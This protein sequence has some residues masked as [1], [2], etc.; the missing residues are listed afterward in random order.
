MLH[1]IF[2]FVP[3]RRTAANSVCSRLRPRFRESV[4]LRTPAVPHLATV[5]RTGLELWLDITSQA[6]SVDTNVFVNLI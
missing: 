2:S 4:S 5:S 3:T 6:W 1:M